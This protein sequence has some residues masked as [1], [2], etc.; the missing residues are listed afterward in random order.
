[1]K[2]MIL[3]ALL[4]LMFLIIPSEAKERKGKTVQP[5]TVVKW[6]Q[7]GSSDMTQ[8]VNLTDEAEKFIKAQVGRKGKLK[9]LSFTDGYRLPSEPPVNAVVSPLIYE[10]NCT[11]TAEFDYSKCKDM[12]T[13]DI[14]YGIFSPLSLPVN[15]TVRLIRKHRNV[16]V[17]LELNGASHL[18]W[19]PRKAK[20]TEGKMPPAI[21]KQKCNFSAETTYTGYIAYRLGEVR[22][23]MPNNDAFNIAS[24]EDRKK[25]LERRGDMLL[26][27]VTGTFL[28]LCRGKRV[29][30]HENN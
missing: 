27:N 16:T 7:E 14:D 17:S 25:G 13:W 2:A 20:S 18:T 24:L 21:V 28:H 12:F 26:Y 1:M 8:M 22:G 3:M 6:S 9:S 4:A 5:A 23:D 30:L 15:V 11:Y 19:S 29:K 10:A